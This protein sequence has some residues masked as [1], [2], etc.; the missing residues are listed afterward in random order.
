M[1]V[2]VSYFRG[3]AVFCIVFSVIFVGHAHAKDMNPKKPQIKIEQIP[4]PTYKK[5][6]FY[7]LDPPRTLR[8]RVERLTHG[9][10]VDM[11]PEYD[12]YGYEIRRFMAKV[13]N[14]AVLDS[15]QN[16]KGQLQNIKFAQKIAAAW[17]ANHLKEVNEINVLIE[18][19]NASSTVRSL[20]NTKKLEAQSFFQHLNGWI[21]YNRDALSYLAEIGTN[22]YQYQDGEFRFRSSEEFNKYKIL[23][24]TRVRALD[25]MHG[26]T[27]FRLMVY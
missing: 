25:R 11:P 23:H 15:T 3:F 18:E 5:V 8:E 17:Q 20:Y 6:T 10:L 1:G 16:I 26:Y 22:R 12:H 24:E 2:H 9:M 27:P 19:Q 14:E 4:E 7:K 21:R 13:G